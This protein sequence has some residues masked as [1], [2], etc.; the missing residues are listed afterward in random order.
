MRH[1]CTLP[2][3]VVL[4]G[5]SG[6][7]QGLPVLN[8]SVTNNRTV[9]I[10]WVATNTGFVLQESTALPLPNWQGSASPVIFNPNNGTFSASVSVTNASYFYRLAPAPVAIKLG[11]AQPI[12]T[13]GNTNA[14]GLFNVPD[15]HT[16][17]LQQSSNSYL[18]WITGNIGTNGGSVGMLSTTYFTNYQNAGPGSATKMGA[19]FTP[20]WDGVNTNDPAITNIDS[21]YVGANAVITA[22]NGHDLLMFYEAG[23]KTYGGTNY[24][25]IVNGQRVGEFNVMALA[26]STDNGLTW[27]RQGTVVSGTDPRPDAP[28]PA[29]QP[30][31]GEPGIVVT[32]GYIYMIY[33]YHPNNPPNPN[34]TGFIQIARAPLA[35]DGA[36]NTW[37]K[38]YTNSWSQPGIGGLGDTILPLK[39][40]GGVTNPEMVWPCISTYL[41]AYVLTFLAD[42]GWYF[43]T[44][45]D[46]LNW[47]SPM[48]FMPALMWQDCQP[49]DWNFIFVTPGNPGGVIGQSGYVLYAHTD[50]KGIGCPGGFSP[51]ELWIRPFT[52]TKNK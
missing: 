50:S 5:A 13:F 30:G 28:P 3:L 16:A 44:S 26:R 51:H 21:D 43:S 36:P 9:L 49:M 7:A 8:L 38:Y 4:C 18:L 15:M 27:T 39:P 11:A 45:T 1:G 40:A 25:G 47:T 33:V 14:M 6:L 19:V 31:V 48:N 10:N 24:S 2:A 12:F 46:L 37:V 17:V 34:Q 23:S 35:S 32:N 20:S 29:N 52:F 22:T 41:N 42:D